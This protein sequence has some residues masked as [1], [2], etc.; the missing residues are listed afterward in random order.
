M[1]ENTSYFKVNVTS[2]KTIEI[3]NNDCLRYIF[4][5]LSILDKI[6]I[7]R[8]SKRWREVS[9]ASWSNLKEINLEPLRPNGYLHERCKKIELNKLIE[10]W[11]RCGKYLENID[12]SSIDGANTLS[13]VAFYCPNTRV[14]KANWKDFERNASIENLKS[15][16]DL[17]IVGVSRCF[18]KQATRL[19]ENNKNLRSL[20]LMNS[21]KLDGSFFLNLP[22]LEILRLNN[23]IFGYSF[24]TQNIDDSMKNMNCL[25]VLTIKPMDNEQ[26]DLI[27]ALQNHFNLEEIDLNLSFFRPAFLDLDKSL[28][29]LFQ[30]NQKIKI[31]SLNGFSLEGECLMNLNCDCIKEL[32]LKWLSDF[33]CKYLNT[34]SNNFKNLNKFVYLAHSNDKD[35][36]NELMKF[37]PSLVNLKHL[38]LSLYPNEPER[39]LSSS[40]LSLKNLEALLLRRCS[41]T[42]E[43]LISFAKNLRYI[44]EVSLFSCSGVTDNGIFA[45]TGLP[46]LEKFSIFFMDKIT[47]N[48][49]NKMLNLRKLCIGCKLPT[50]KVVEKILR[51][52]ERLEYLYLHHYTKGITVDLLI[53]ANEITKSRKNNIVL[54]IH[55]D[56]LHKFCGKESLKNIKKSPFL[57][58]TDEF[59]H[60]L[61]K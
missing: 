18:P 11:K 45:I 10:I 19:F 16:V 61:F 15:L 34:Y 27:I 25:K 37:I 26:N 39:N 58:Y 12:A 4:C 22:S 41:L 9:K 35:Y 53:K 51:E 17:T 55:E 20:H 7:E 28:K 57:N 50:E 30:N 23:G 14:L 8:V 56:M 36:Y 24:V 40:V 59:P 60:S 21:R 48:G 49:F 54:Y 3:L 43:S 5:H 32:S 46:Q 38:H 6:K 29:L 52:S 44:K 33:D 2:I 13:F 47:D 1:N 31:F 42:D